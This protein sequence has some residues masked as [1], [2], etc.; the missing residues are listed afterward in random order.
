M[1]RLG[2]P[3][4][5]ALLA[6]GLLLEQERDQRVGVKLVADASTRDDRRDQLVTRERIALGHALQRRDLFDREADPETT[7]QPSR[8]M[9]GLEQSASSA[10]SSDR[11]RGPEDSRSPHHSHDQR[12]HHGDRPR[13]ARRDPRHRRGT[14]SGDDR[15]ASGPAS[16]HSTSSR[17]RCTRRTRSV[18]GTPA[19]SAS[20]RWACPSPGSSR[21]AS[22][23]RRDASPP[24]DF[25]EVVDVFA[26]SASI[27]AR[28][29]RRVASATRSRR[30]R[31]ARA[32][33]RSAARGLSRRAPSA[34]TRP[35]RSAT[36]IASPVSRDR[37][38]KLRIR[39]SQVRSGDDEIST[40][41]VRG[42]PEGS[43]AVSQL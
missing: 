20:R 8:P 39:T 17:G 5:A 21:C 25:L 31:R 6:L 36:R 1:P 41:R 42:R 28:P 32:W 22:R 7:V 16:R 9:I 38:V 11:R 13:R 2:E 30:W 23:G 15:R 34:G 18:A 43:V 12:Q 10:G 29:S 35:E 27:I 26:G 3:L 4:L 19:R 14:R 37:L 24:S 33:R 40:S